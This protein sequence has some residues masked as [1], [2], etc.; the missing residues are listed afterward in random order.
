M[1]KLMNAAT[2]SSNNKVHR[3]FS[4]IDFVEKTAEPYYRDD[5]FSFGS[6]TVTRLS[7]GKWKLNYITGE[8]AIV[9]D[10]KAMCSETGDFEWNSKTADLTAEIKDYV[11]VY[12]YGSEI[13]VVASSVRDGHL[14]GF[15]AEDALVLH[16]SVLYHLKEKYKNS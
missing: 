16:M 6:A 3:L 14:C 7:D 13:F 11:Y 2:A 10:I 8:T 9:S 4:L 5:G 15:S 12:G 1:D